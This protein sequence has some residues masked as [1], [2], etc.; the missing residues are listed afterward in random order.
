MSR[1]ISAETASVGTVASSPVTRMTPPSSARIGRYILERELARGGMGVVYLAYD[2]QLERYAAVKLLADAAPRQ[3]LVREARAM[4]RLSHPNVVTV[5]DVLSIDNR[6][7]VA[8]ELMEGGTLS[9]WLHAKPRRRRDILA[10]FQAAGR[11]LAAAHGA[12]LV[13]RDFKPGNVLRAGGGR[14]AVTDFGLARDHDGAIPPGPRSDVVVVPGAHADPSG[15]GSLGKRLGNPTESSILGT[16]PYMAP[17]Q[18]AGDEVTPATDQFA[19][20]VTLWEALAGHRPFAGAS[21]ETLRDAIA[22]G[23]RD[24][25]TARIPRRLRAI[26]A[27]GLDPVPANRW[28]DINALLAAIARAERRPRVIAI[29]AGALAVVGAAVAAA[30]VLS[31]ARGAQPCMGLDPQPAIDAVWD[32]GRG[33]APE[34]REVI[35]ADAASWKTL[36]GTACED[37]S[38][39]VAQLECLSAVS[40]RIGAVVDGATRSSPKVA[41]WIPDWLVD[42]AV[43]A[44]DTPPRLMASWSPTAVAAIIDMAAAS[45]HEPPIPIPAASPPDV[46]GGLL[47][48]PDQAIR[49]D[50]PGGRRARLDDIVAAADTCDERLRVDALLAEI[51]TAPYAMRT[52]TLLPVARQ[53][54]ARVSQSDLVAQLDY[55]ESM[56]F[57]RALRYDEALALL[58]HARDAFATRHRHGWELELDLEQM[59]DRFTRFTADDLAEVDRINARLASSDDERAHLVSKLYAAWNAWRHDDFAAAH[60]YFDTLADDGAS[61]ESIGKPVTGIVV[62]GRGSPVA[63][64]T[65][66]A[67]ATLDLD[68]IGWLP[69]S[70]WL[71]VVKSDD[72]GAFAVS[73]PSGAVVIALHGTERSLP[74]HLDDGP[75]RLQL[76]PTR[77]ISGVVD[78]WTS[79][80]LGLIAAFVPHAQ[81]VNFVARLGADGSFAIDGVP[82]VPM[83]LQVE[84]SFT[85]HGSSIVAVDRRGSID[86]LRMHLAPA[87]RTVHL[88]IRSATAA[89]AIAAA[90]WFVEDTKPLPTLSGD[91]WRLDGYGSQLAMPVKRGTFAVDI[92]NVPRVPML[93]CAVGEFEGSEGDPDADPRAEQWFAGTANRVT[94]EHLAVD[95]TSVVLAVSPTEL[96]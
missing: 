79:K 88:E 43:C 3:R 16:P 55:Y 39:H 28:P 46:C 40:A 4:A 92:P 48:Q 93:A 30:L 86:R 10:A 19:F 41:Q 73:V 45:T 49:S 71:R 77:R 60:A 2:P 51:H 75:V 67:S 54:V 57:A 14:F 61:A 91:V 89:A 68:A 62:D 85:E 20:C 35:G 32:G 29:G 8:M 72:R 7:V 90:V 70:D 23:P 5:Y 52:A 18:W 81:D 12:G 11:G 76:G 22:R 9:D 37:P 50:D 21:D 87:D 36:R 59:F 69:T 74:R 80:R 78:G 82:D 31:P 44:R 6:D 58:E 38:H 47:A 1:D 63:G 96:R 53:A 33:R 13:H 25:D 95:A 27:R 42:P 17:E 64:A 94:C 15:S 34:V 56:R 24:L 26:L 83:H 66:L 65:I 84:G